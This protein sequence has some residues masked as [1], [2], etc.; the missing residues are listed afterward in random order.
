MFHFTESMPALIRMISSD[1]G[2]VKEIYVSYYLFSFTE[3]M[4]ALIRMI[5]SDNGNVKE[6][7]T[8]ALA[9]LTTANSSNCM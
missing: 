2:N 7:A 3:G 1:N 5:S 9:N 4:P 6:A 8:L